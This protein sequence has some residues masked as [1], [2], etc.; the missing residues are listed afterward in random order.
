MSNVLSYIT[1]YEQPALDTD[2]VR[3]SCIAK[4]IQRKVI[5]NK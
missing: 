5:L 4:A 3:K 2:A 1:Q